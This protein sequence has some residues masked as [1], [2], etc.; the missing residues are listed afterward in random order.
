MGHCIVLDVDGEPVRFQLTVPPDHLTDEDRAGLIELA[1]A[2]RA[3][4]EKY[5]RT[6]KG[7]HPRTE[8]TPACEPRRTRLATPTPGCRHTV[9][10]YDDQGRGTCRLCHSAV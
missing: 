1:R 3:D 4:A 5:H 7:K 10:E 8:C 2:V 6:A 9:I